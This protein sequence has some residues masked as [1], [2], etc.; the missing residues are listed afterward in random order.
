MALFEINKNWNIEDCILGFNKDDEFKIPTTDEIY[1]AIFENNYSNEIQENDVTVLKNKLSFSKYPVELK[2]VLQ[3][4][5]TG[6]FS[7]ELVLQAILENGEFETLSPKYKA[8]HIVIKNTW[9]PFPTGQLE[10]LMH[11]LDLADIYETGKIRLGQYLSLLKLGSDSVKNDVQFLNSNQSETESIEKPCDLK[12]DLYKYQKKGWEWLRFMRQEKIG[13]ILADEMGLGKTIQIISLFCSEKKDIFPALI[14]SPATLLENWRREIFKF[15]SHINTHIHQGPKRTGFPNE[16]KKYNVV[17]TSYE[18]VIRDISLISQIDWKVVV[19]DEAQ[20]IKNPQ[21]K[22]AISVKKIPREIGFAVTGTPIEN[23]L[24]DLWSIMDFSA[25]G[26]LGTQTVF[27]T[28]FK[29]TTNGASQLEKIISPLILRRRVTQVAKDLPAKIIIPQVLELNNDESNLY[30]QIRIET[31]NEF[32]ANASLVVLSRLRLFCTHP[33]LIQDKPGEDP[34][35]YSN[36][37]K[38]LVE[39]VEEIVANGAKILVFTSFTKMIDIIV[40][41]IKNR[42]GIYSNSIDGRTA[43]NDRQKIIDEFSTIEG[44][45]LLALNPIAA[46]AGLNITAANHVIHYNLE[47]NPAKED[48]ASARA[49]R[50]GQDRPVTIHR[51]F[52]ANTVEEAIDERLDRKRLLAGTAI[53]GVQGDAD[54]YK[55]ILNAIHKSPKENE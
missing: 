44:S 53:V 1:A 54:D 16:I 29:Q 7:I 26:F 36:K 18:T 35:N 22:R 34:T 6:N 11:T 27:E 43:I 41:D 12:A 15:A 20:A 5:E 30:E 31:I 37:F 46:G 25:P 49:Y 13:G 33:F 21:T 28:N 17:I 50:R 3:S 45:A 10:E 48:Q 38:R 40:S 52:Y 24:T 51:L 42:F 2:I 47:W 8:D 32:K 23:S 19:C 9:Y 14:I 55:D 39:I 4:K